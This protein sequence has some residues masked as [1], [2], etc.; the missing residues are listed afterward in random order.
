MIKLKKLTIYEVL[1]ELCK[2]NTL[3]RDIVVATADFGVE[4][5]GEPKHVTYRHKDIDTVDYV[6]TEIRNMLLDIRK[7]CISGFEGRKDGQILS[8]LGQT[9]K[10]KK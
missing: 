10:E 7:R 3:V 9:I 2:I 1:E 8:K 5:G 4:E 6:T